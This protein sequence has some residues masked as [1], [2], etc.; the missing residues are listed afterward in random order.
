MALHFP[1]S[2][3]LRAIGQSLEAQN[4][5]AFELIASD[6]E[7]VV[8]GRIETSERKPG[9]LSGWF[10][11]GKEKPEEL[12]ELRFDADEIRRLGKL[13]E[14]HRQNPGQQP[15]YFRLS[16]TLRT[17]GAYIDHTNFKFRRLRRTGPRLELDFEESGGQIRNEEHLVNSFHNYF[18]QLYMR[19]GQPG[20]ARGHGKTS[21][22]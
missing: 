9:L 5:E 14:E 10:R 15:D 6:N 3:T 17:V 20:S 18:L 19:R 21:C 8:R 2:H 22:S 12:V 11:R 1:Y 4:I 13:G 16:Q 7:L